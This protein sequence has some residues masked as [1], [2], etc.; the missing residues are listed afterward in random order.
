ML[1]FVAPK[2]DKAVEVSGFSPALLLG[3]LE[4]E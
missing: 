1:D 2:Q 4:N 3:G